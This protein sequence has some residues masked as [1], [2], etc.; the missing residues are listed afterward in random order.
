MIISNEIGNEGANFISE[1]LKS[2]STLTQLYLGIN[3][4]CY[5]IN[6][7]IYITKFTTKE[8]RLL[9]NL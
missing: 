9:G 3:Y 2:N 7:N 1:L 4:S 6:T 5:F 8:S